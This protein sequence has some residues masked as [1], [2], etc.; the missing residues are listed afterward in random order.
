MRPTRGDTLLTTAQAAQ[1]V[2]VS[3][4]TIRTWRHR[5]WLTP[6]LDERNRPLYMQTVRAAERT[7]RENGLRIS[8]V[9]PR[10]L[11]H[12]SN[13]AALREAL[14]TLTRHALRASPWP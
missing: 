12:A 7:V 10:Q 4:A 13:P 5:G 11:R 2:G 14:W 1:I 6:G 9:D 3:P 8:G